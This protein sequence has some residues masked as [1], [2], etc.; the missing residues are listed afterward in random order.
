MLSI[1]SGYSEPTLDLEVLLGCSYFL[2]AS[3]TTQ[4]LS[5]MVSQLCHAE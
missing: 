3:R 1:G 2:H 5:L 4:S